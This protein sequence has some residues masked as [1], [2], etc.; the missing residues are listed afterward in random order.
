M[1]W[2]VRRERDKRARMGARLSSRIKGYDRR[3]ELGKNISSRLKFSGKSSKMVDKMVAKQK[4]ARKNLVSLRN[5]TVKNLSKEEIQRGER[6][7]K[8]LR[9]GLGAAAG[10]A[11]LP[12]AAL[13]ST[14]AGG[15]YLTTAGTIAFTAA[16]ASVLASATNVASD[17]IM[18]ERFINNH[19]TKR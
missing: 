7:V 9:Y 19:V 2:G 1:K 5:K 8:G 15:T 13:A 12:G 4:T 3:I 17:K 6:F 18:V 10:L 14:I 11:I 16:K